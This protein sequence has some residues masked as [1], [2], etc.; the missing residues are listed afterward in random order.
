MLTFK[1]FRDRQKKDFDSSMYIHGKHANKK[2]NEVIETEF[3]DSSHFKWK[4][5]K[6]DNQHLGDKPDAQMQRLESDHPIHDDHL[7]AIKHYTNDSFSL[8]NHLIDSHNKKIAP[9]KNH[10]GHD[11]NAIENSFKPSKHD[12]DSF[13]GVGSDPREFKTVKKVG[14]VDIKAM[15]AHFSSSLQRR[16]AHGFARG[17][18]RS[19][20]AKNV[21]R[22]IIH[23]HIKKGDPIS[24]IGSKSSYSDNT[25]QYGEH[26]VLLPRTCNELG[27]YHMAHHKTD[28][29]VDANGDKLFVHHCSL[30]KPK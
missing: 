17:Q 9:N 18:V 3:P 6:S 29:H 7:K 4:Q 28:V 14:D 15:P 5:D 24:P 26:E 20:D 1:E 10:G 2:I 22:H 27:N 16:T 11:L 21:D 25:H 19:Q 30:V 8:T 12:F 23:W 13:T